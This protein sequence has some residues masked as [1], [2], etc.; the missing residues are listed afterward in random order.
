M[1]SFHLLF[2]KL[3]HHSYQSSALWLLEN[4]KSNTLFL[5]YYHVHYKL[6]RGGFTIVA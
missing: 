2:S 1:C 6:L 5:L 3:T 4:R